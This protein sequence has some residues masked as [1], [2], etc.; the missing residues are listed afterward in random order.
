MKA[1][2]I[3]LSTISILAFAAVGSFAQSTITLDEVLDQVRTISFSI[4][5][6]RTDIAIAISEEGNKFYKS[7]LKPSLTL[8][9]NLPNYNK[10]SSAIIQPDGTIAFQSI[11]QANSSVSLF[12]TQAITKTGGTIFLNTD[13][14]RFDDLSSEFKTYNGIPI[15]LGISQPL[16]GYNPWKYEKGYTTLTTTRGEKEFQ[17]RCRICIE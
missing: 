12:A 1:V 5:S 7:L 15:R 6:A 8:R 11:R 9:A 13:L 14:Q 2:Q 4:K 16:F 17:Y 3:I 10:T